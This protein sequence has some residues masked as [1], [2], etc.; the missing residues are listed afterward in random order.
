MND[1]IYIDS[2]NGDIQKLLP[3]EPLTGN[4]TDRTA[5]EKKA[6]DDETNPDRT[7]TEGN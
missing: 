1:L 4:D 7:E 2:G 3:I 5:S 6:S